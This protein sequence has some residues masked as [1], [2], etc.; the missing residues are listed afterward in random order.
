MPIYDQVCSNCGD[1]EAFCA[2]KDRHTCEDCGGPCVTRPPLVN[3][4]GIIFSNV[5]TSSQLGTRWETNA[6]KRE[7]LKRHPNARPMTKGSPEEKSFA[8]GLKEK[9]DSV[10]KH[11]GFKDVR[12]YKSEVKKAKASG[13][14][15]LE[16]KSG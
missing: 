1:V 2:P 9:E 13:H 3:I 6:Q 5:E 16:S 14:K 15:G 7:W 10:M 11:H 8:N 4:H 12:H